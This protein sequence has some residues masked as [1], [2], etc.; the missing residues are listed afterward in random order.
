MLPNEEEF[1]W[2]AADT[3]TLLNNE[4]EFLWRAADTKTLLNGTARHLLWNFNPVCVA[5]EAFS[6]GI[7]RW[8][9]VL[10]GEKRPGASAGGVGNEASAGGLRRWPQDGSPEADRPGA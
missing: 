10:G 7:G 8:G 5:W 9:M 6:G 1:L 2:R 4:E 3:K